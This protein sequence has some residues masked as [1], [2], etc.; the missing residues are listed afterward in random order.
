MLPLAKIHFSESETDHGETL[1]WY[2][3][4][5]EETEKSPLVTESNRTHKTATIKMVFLSINKNV[6]QVNVK[7]MK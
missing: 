6:M 2:C 3:V 4:S 7:N 5:I 1:M